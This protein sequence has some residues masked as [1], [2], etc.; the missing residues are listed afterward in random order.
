MQSCDVVI[1]GMGPIGAAGAILLGEAGL[2][3]AVIEPER[4]VYPL[5]RAVGMDGEIVRAF[6]A[7]GRSDDL[8]AMLQPIRPGSR[9]GFANSSREWLFGQDLREFGPS[10]WPPLSMFDQPEVDRYLRDVAISHPNVTAHIGFAAT[11]L[12]DEA[13]SVTVT[14]KDDSSGEEI[15]CAGRYVIGCDGANS[16]VRQQRNI[17]WLDMGYNRDWLVVDVIAKEGNTLGNDVLQVCDPDRLTT[18]IAT[19]DPYRRWE[20]RLNPGETR[21]EM[22][23]PERIMEL[24]DD[25]TPRDTYEIHRAAVYQFHATV[26][27]I[28]RDGRILI[29]GDA[30]HQTPPFLGQGMNSGMRDV[31]NL[32]W[33]L[34]LI[35]NGTMSENLLDS[36]FDE[37]MGHSEDLIDWAVSL[38]KLMEHIAATEAAARGDAPPPGEP[39]PLSAGYGQGRMI[40]PL[41]AGLLMAEQVSDTGSSGYQLQ[42]PIVRLADGK[43]CR[44]DDVLGSGFAIAARDAKSVQLNDA[45]RAIVE[46]LGITIVALTDFELERGRFDPLFDQA[47][48]A[49]I[50]PDRYIFG[51]TTDQVSLDDLI[52]A[53]SAKLGFVPD[54]TVE[55]QKPALV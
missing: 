6:Q 21:D 20:F 32:A 27:E 12:I 40:P 28:W 14:A 5:P 55:P 7:I 16:F 48:A 39:P 30:A 11:D 31:I 2:S 10:G 35:I 13:N 41:K 3:V 38:G 46:A 52:E 54:Q 50:R 15:R 26:A 22:L 51:H 23:A 17:G 25:W 1:V 29:A 42:Q 37:R 9:A 36:Y 45:S 43:S 53:L 44:L 47:S 18:Y 19:K 8:A 34:P 49:L 24:I 33:K 4:D